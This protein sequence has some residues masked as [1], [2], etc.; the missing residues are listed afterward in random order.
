MLKKNIQQFIIFKNETARNFKKHF[1]N[2]FDAAQ[3]AS[4]PFHEL[5]KLVSI[6]PEY[7]ENFEYYFYKLIAFGGNINQ[8]DTNGNT[9]LHYALQN[10]LNKN[11]IH[12]FLL[13]GVNLSIANALSEYALESAVKANHYDDEAVFSIMGTMLEQIKNSI[14]ASDLNPEEKLAFWN[15]EINFHTFMLIVSNAPT[16]IVNKLISYGGNFSVP[17]LESNHHTLNLV[18]YYLNR[19]NL[20]DENVLNRLLDN[21]DLLIEAGA[22]VNE[23]NTNGDQPLHVVIK[24]YD[25]AYSIPII[26]H[27]LARGAN[28]NA[29]N[30]SLQTP[31]H[32]VADLFYLN[33]HRGEDL[34]EL[35]ELLIKANANV[36]A[37]DAEGG[38]TPFYLIMYNIDKKIHDPELIK[39]LVSLFHK[40]NVDFFALKPDQSSIYLSELSAPATN[41]IFDLTIESSLNTY[42]G[43]NLDI[44]IYSRLEKLYTIRYHKGHEKILLFLNS[45]IKYNIPINDN[46]I[47]I[48]LDLKNKYPRSNN[49]Y[50]EV[51]IKTLLKHYKPSNIDNF[52]NNMALLVNSFD[53]IFCDIILDHAI[54]YIRSYV[55]INEQHQKITQLFAQ[56]VVTN[57]VDEPKIISFIKK[58]KA[59]AI[60]IDDTFINIITNAKFTHGNTTIF[61]NGTVIENMLNLYE[62]KDEQTLA[63]SLKALKDVFKDCSKSNLSKI[64][65]DKYENHVINDMSIDTKP[66]AYQAIAKKIQLK[67]IKE[68][69]IGQVVKEDA[70]MFKAIEMLIQTTK[71][72]DHLSPLIS[73]IASEFIKTSSFI[74]SD[75]PSPI[76][77][78]IF[79]YM[80][81][82]IFQ[83]KI[84]NASLFSNKRALEIDQNSVIKKRKTVDQ[85]NHTPK[86]CSIF[87]QQTNGS[88]R[89]LKLSTKKRVRSDQLCSLQKAP[90]S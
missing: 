56:L 21:I 14:N 20:Q 75:M 59:H 28:I 74:R 44:E 17:I 9:A 7:N 84:E 26:R 70:I 50:Q 88:S 77:K 40:E 76:K 87:S 65:I 41:A 67:L 66:N 1:K 27:L 10:K 81:G 73:K 64:A 68:N 22:D 36:F 38:R 42:K 72:N 13:N 34:F 30:I 79:S 15:N 48:L 25:A 51:I 24:E 4:H 11:W 18:M 32:L 53:G 5:I 90:Q 31:L 43:S 35:I 82:N 49:L 16:T 33:K 85:S 54:S 71:R 58:L 45:I 37:Q 19:L 46:F 83:E 60:H 86:P 89:Q 3:F 39:K 62:P 6:Y 57:L 55:N 63:S 47:L 52:L 23:E 2:D 61:E 29:S 69:E 78:M 12:H 8:V 80:P